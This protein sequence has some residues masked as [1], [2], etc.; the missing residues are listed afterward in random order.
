MFFCLQVAKLSGTGEKLYTA[1][2]NNCP[3][4]ATV[5]K[6]I[7]LYTENC[8]FL[9]LGHFFTIKSM[10]DAFEGATRVHVI[11]YG[12]GYGVEFPSLMQQLLQRPEGPPHLRITG[13]YSLCPTFPLTTI[14]R[15]LRNY[16]LP[17]VCS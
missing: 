9:K 8:P 10:V 7:R 17:L 4:A 12:I 14:W 5:F 13:I 15:H 3:S 11:F 16:D 2:T 6:A 1:I